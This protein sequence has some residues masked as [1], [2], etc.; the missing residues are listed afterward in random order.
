MPV[1]EPIFDTNVE[2]T[3]LTIDLHYLDR[4]VARMLGLPPDK[5]RRSS[6]QQTEVREVIAEGL[7]MAYQHPEVPPFEGH[8]WTFLTPSAWLE[9]T[10]DKKWYRLPSD[11]G[12]I[13]EQVGLTYSDDHPGYGPIRVVNEAF[14]MRN[15]SAL[16]TSAYPMFAAV[17]QIDSEG[18]APQ[19]FEVGFFPIPS[20]D[21][22]LRYRYHA[23][24][25]MLTDDE[26]YP[27]GGNI[28]GQ[29]FLAASEAAAEMYENDGRGPYYQKFI[30]TLRTHVQLD[31]RNGAQYMG[32][33]IDSSRSW[34][35][36]RRSDKVYQNPVT[37]KGLKWD[38]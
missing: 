1:D 27:L 34:H 32:K 14:L 21:Y 17:R 26:P 19:R 18:K 8:R 5:S 28:H 11:F 13:D 33:N 4:R 15:E 2:A 23:M 35:P 6:A 10:A 36:G 38:S 25:Q 9:T 20:A 22:R 29:L 37:Y 31:M 7:R 24:P 30:E 3:T 12:H 16:T